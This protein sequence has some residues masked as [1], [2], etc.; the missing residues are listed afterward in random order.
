ML[1]FSID[2]VIFL[3]KDQDTRKVP[4]GRYVDGLYQLMS[5]PLSSS[6]RQDHGVIKSKSSH[7]HMR[8]GH[9]SFSVV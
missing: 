4:Q 1:L 8:L 2:L 3:I 5:S 9:P 6:G 7:W